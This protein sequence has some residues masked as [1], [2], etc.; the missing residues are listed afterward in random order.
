MLYLCQPAGSEAPRLPGSGLHESSK[1]WYREVRPP[2]K[3]RHSKEVVCSE[4]EQDSFGTWM[5]HGPVA[6]VRPTLPVVALQRMACLC[7]GRAASPWGRLWTTL[8]GLPTSRWG[9][10]PTNLLS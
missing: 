7:L 5:S 4:I 6:C 1:G 10:A 9:P 2:P 8:S 3:Q